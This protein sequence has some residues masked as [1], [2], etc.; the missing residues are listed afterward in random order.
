[1]AQMGLTMVDVGVAQEGWPATTLA[2]IEQYVAN[3]GST[4]SGSEKVTKKHT[5]GGGS[6]GG[7]NVSNQVRPPQAFLNACG[8]SWGQPLT[9]RL[10]DGVTP[11]IN[12]VCVGPQNDTSDGHYLYYYRDHLNATDPERDLVS[13]H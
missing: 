5:G 10:K 1:M 13:V 7:G 3:S 12:S 9:A 4:G 8:S 6:G 2:G 11:V